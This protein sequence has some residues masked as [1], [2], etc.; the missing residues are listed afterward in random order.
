[1]SKTAKK[2]IQRRKRAV[3][4]RK[5]LSGTAERPR[6]VVFRSN[7]HIYG[8]VIDD[9]TGKTLASASTLT[10]SVKAKLEGKKADAAKLVG[11][12]IGTAAKAA[13]VTKVAFD[14]NGFKYHGRVAALAD[15]ARK[16]GLEF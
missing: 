7:K 14:R 5:T 12:A 9:D 3:H 10:A 4:V 15:A 16:A 6:L 11:E 2:L 1:M 8:Q 13:G